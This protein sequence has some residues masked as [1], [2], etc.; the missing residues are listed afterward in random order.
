[1]HSERDDPGWLDQR[2]TSDDVSKNV[3]KTGLTQWPRLFH[4]LRASRETELVEQFPV[5][6]VTAWLGNTPSVALKHYLMAT[7]EHF[8]KAVQNPVQH[9]SE[10]PDTV[11]QS[12]SDLNEQTPVFRGLD[13]CRNSL[14]QNKL[15]P[16]GFE[17]TTFA[18]RTRRSPN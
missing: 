15:E 18:L 17:P 7:E 2:E 6:V 3:R 5:Q 4:N 1:L 12:R 13:V 14:Q 11:S 16:M 8:Q 9:T 10:M